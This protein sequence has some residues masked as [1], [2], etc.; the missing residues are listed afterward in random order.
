[1]S[2]AVKVNQVLLGDS[3]DPTK[4]FKITVPTPEDGTLSITRGDGSLLTNYADDTAAAA[5]GVPVGG[6][7]RTASALKVRVA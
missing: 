4:N 3:A 5:G 7:Y 1:M 6:I 2:G